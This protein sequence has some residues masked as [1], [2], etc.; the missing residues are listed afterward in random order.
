MKHCTTFLSALLFC[1]VFLASCSDDS[2][3][4]AKTLEETEQEAG[5]SER[6]VN[7]VSLVERAEASEIAPMTVITDSSGNTIATFDT[8]AATAADIQAVQNIKSFEGT[9]SGRAIYIAITGVDSRVGE[10]TPHADA[11]H[12]ISVYPD[13]G[14][15]LITS[16]P[17]DTP[18]DAGFE[19]DSMQRFNILANVLPNRSRKSYHKELARIAGVPRIDNYIEIGFSQA[20]G[21][22][23]L[24]GYKNPKNTLRVLR[25]RKGLGGDDYQ[26]CYNQGQFI[27]QAILR[28][29][30]KLD[31]FLGGMAVRGGLLLV[32]S[33]LSAD[34]ANSIIEA[35]SAKKFGDSPDDVL[36]RIR[37]KMQ[38]NFKVYTFDQNTIDS[39]D[40]KI[41]SFNKYMKKKDSSFALKGSGDIDARL[42]NML[43]LAA[44]DT[45]SRPRNVI[46]RLSRSFEQHAWLQV[47]DPAR[48]HDI[49][50][51]FAHYLTTAYRKLGKESEAQNIQTII[52][53][54]EELFKAQQ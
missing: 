14:K 16:I 3:R 38:Q 2:N 39:L 43:A 21:V 7:G 20:I 53:T 41:D 30:S 6:R 4:P 36:V 28:H 34:R 29:F 47:S 10:R 48:R 49:R 8:S 26:R 32:D 1:I 50:S 19:A 35:L 9:I 31:G 33:D 52:K 44:K 27:R 23:E 45:A 24:L 22:M 46:N 5:A 18:A 42:N 51:K 12:V 25:S 15:I 11:N 54:E 17:R 40:K 37:P 13:S